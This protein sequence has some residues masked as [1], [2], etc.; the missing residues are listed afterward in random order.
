MEM[1][2]KHSNVSFFLDLFFKNK[3]FPPFYKKITNSITN[4]VVYRTNSN[5]NFRINHTTYSIS[6][7]PDYFLPQLINTDKHLKLLTTSLYT[8]YLINLTAF[9]DLEDYL[10]NKLGRPR[11]S[12]LKRYRKRLDLCIAPEYKIFYGDILE[13][14]YLLLFKYLFSMTEQRFAQ[15]EEFNFELP[16][17]ELY[18]DMMYPLI[19]DKKACIFA[20]YH[21]NKPIN[22][23]LNFIDGD[24]IFHWNSCYDTD[25]QMFNLGHI[26]MVNHL[27]WAFQNSFKLFDMGRGDFL[28]KRKYV[29][30][31]YMYNEHVLYDSKSLRASIIAYLKIIKLKIRFGVIQILKKTSIHLWYGKY[32]KYKY[33]LIKAKS[34]PTKEIKFNIDNTTSEIPKLENLDTIDLSKDEYSF[35][36]KP[37]NYFLHKS[38]ELVNNVSIYKELDN[39]E[40]YYFKG[41]KRTQKIL[42]AD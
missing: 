11:K 9:K 30:E 6:D 8:G 40:T 26:N 31:N 3:G 38:Q 4:H 27:E 25:Y 18:Q 24:T 12:Q 36:I 34:K 20:I 23:T 2:K 13:H 16:Y 5:S 19:L 32:V 35:L 41:L 37:L 7:I 33:R 28:H 14:E 29:N 42:I 10:N 39:K 15:K 22:I 17:L 1:N 21:N